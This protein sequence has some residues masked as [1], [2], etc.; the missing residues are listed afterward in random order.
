M[1]GTAVRGG[2][3]GALV[4]VPTLRQVRSLHLGLAE[5]LAE[6]IEKVPYASGTL[7]RLALPEQVGGVGPQV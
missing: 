7:S 2:G 1:R 3:A 6:P 5:L 4:V